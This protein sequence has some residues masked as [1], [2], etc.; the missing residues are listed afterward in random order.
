MFD[1]ALSC[2]GQNEWVSERASE[3]E[4][5][6][7]RARERAR[8]GERAS[9]QGVSCYD[10]LPLFQTLSII[11]GF[12]KRC[13]RWKSE[14]AI[15]LYMWLNCMMPATGGWLVKCLWPWHDLDMK[16]IHWSLSCISSGHAC[17]SVCVCQWHTSDCTYWRERHV[18]FRSP[19]YEIIKDISLCS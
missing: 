17:Q 15:C 13:L 19:L 8:E 6:S 5:V 9:I 10:T 7:E 4:W 18:R 11:W 2:S 14:L 16:T 12:Q 1:S 3:R